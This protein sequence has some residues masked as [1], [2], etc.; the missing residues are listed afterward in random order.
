MLLSMFNPFN[1]L[2]GRVFIWFWAALL[3]ILLSAFFLAKQLTN[4]VE[5]NAVSDEQAAEST[6]AMQRLVSV[7]ERSG[8]MSQALRRLGQRNGRQLVAINTK[9]GKFRYS[10]PAPLA[11]N[12]AELARFIDS[13]NLLLIRLNNMEFVGPF[14]LNINAMEYKIYIGRLLLR[15]ERTVMSRSKVAIAGLV[16]AILL[17][18]VFCFGLVLS[19][20]KPLG[21]LRSASNKLAKGDLST[22]IK[23]LETRKDEVGH[24]AQDFNTM[25]QRLQSLIDSQKQ[26]MANMSHELRTPLTRLQLAV[27][28]LEDE[29]RLH[30][31]N[32]NHVTEIG[33]TKHLSR[34]ENEIVKMDEMIGQVL[35]IAKINAS[36]QQVN[37]Q[38]TSLETLLNSLLQDAQF[39]AEAMHK[40]LKVGNIPKVNIHA[41]PVLIVSAIE[42][43]VR[44]AIR[45]SSTEVN[46]A[47][48][49]ERAYNSTSVLNS[50][51]VFNKPKA[52]TQANA[53][54]NF[55]SIIISDDGAGMPKEDLER[56]FDPFFRANNQVQDASKGSGLGLSIAKAA[57]E[58][59]GGSIRAEER[60]GVD[61]I[62]LEEQ[63][64]LSGLSVIITLPIIEH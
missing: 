60:K 37:L 29:I 53:K 48:T 19:I 17:S 38:L 21:A 14:S 10:F 41:D 31:A 11:G 4:V 12:S 28:L 23:G 50:A 43:I 34:I 7:V 18:T 33:T 51:R 62:S 47:F 56:V 5:V 22:R 59:H 44:N 30:N 39:E 63:S 3:V 6:Q 64:P 57:I 61:T 42:N 20:T 2:F 35:T 13:E 24:L 26:L 52:D 45:F 32:A 15:S 40:T 46:C 55:I 49:F 16:L 58:I 54:Q 27:A 1:S 8:N 9:S 36:Q 25:A